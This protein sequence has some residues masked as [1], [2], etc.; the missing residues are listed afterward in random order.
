[1]TVYT[2]NHDFCS[3]SA[4][5]GFPCPVQTGSQKFSVSQ[6]TPPSAPAGNFKMVVT[7]FNADQSVVSCLT[8]PVKLVK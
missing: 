6:A 3:A 5:A 2:E 1:M 7:V 8:G 4:V